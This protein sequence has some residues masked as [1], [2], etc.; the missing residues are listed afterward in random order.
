M[1]RK[2]MVRKVT[3]VVESEEGFSKI[4]VTIPAY[5]SKKQQ[6]K[7]VNDAVSSVVSSDVD[8]I[9]TV[10]GEKYSTDAELRLVKIIE[11]WKE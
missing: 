4:T 9:K 1:I 5:G 6:M 2:I 7:E 3:C 11:D 10:F 8:I